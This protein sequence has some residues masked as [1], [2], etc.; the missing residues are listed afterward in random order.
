M[1]SKAM[2]PK[3]RSNGQWKDSIRGDYFPDNWKVLAEEV[4]GEANYV[5]Q[6]GGHRCTGI[7]T[8]VD[9]IDGNRENHER[10]NLQAIC[11]DC[12]KEKSSREG[13]E[14]RFYVGDKEEAE[15]PANITDKNGAEDSLAERVLN[16]KS[17]KDFRRY[18]GPMHE[19]DANGF[20]KLPQH[21]IGRIVI[22]WITR[23]LRHK[24]EP[25]K[26]T[27][28]QARFI[29]W[30]YAVNES[31]G[32]LNRKAIM[33]RSKGWG[34]DP[35][36]AALCAV[37]F[38]GPCRFDGYDSQGRIRAKEEQDAWVQLLAVTLKQN[39]N[40]MLI[41]KSMFSEELK[42][43]YGLE[44]NAWDI[45]ALGGTRFIECI[46]S[47]ANALEGNR[48]TFAICNETQ[49]WVQSN[50]GHYLWEIL[51]G[52]VSKVQNSHMLSITN[53]YNPALDSIAQQQFETCE[54]FAD[55]KTSDP[56]ILIDYRGVS[57]DIPLKTIEERLEAL[58]FAYQDSTQ[59][60][61][62][63]EIAEEL[64]DASVDVMNYGR[65]F[66][67]M[68][69]I[70][71]QTWV[72]IRE[73]DRCA[74]DAS[75][76]PYGSRIVLA[77]DGSLNDDCTVLLGIVV[78]GKYD[79]L[80]IPLGIWS[81]PPKSAGEA[82]ENYRVPRE[83]V[84]K[85]VEEIHKLYKVIAFFADPSHKKDNNGGGSYWMPYINRWNIRYSNKYQ[86]HANPGKHSV[87]WDMTSSARQKDFRE[88]LALLQQ[89]ITD[90]TV[91]HNGDK[92]LRAHVQNARVSVNINGDRSISKV[93]S[94][95]DKKIDYA[96]VWGIAFM[97]YMMVTSSKKTRKNT[98]RSAQPANLVK[99][100]D[101]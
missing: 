54:K 13:V 47:S 62:V 1:H 86:F 99:D 25:F 88:A 32:W 41:L 80:A 61:N 19:R 28:E 68:I 29:M 12:H 35:L 43:R 96:V 8:E 24:G 21:T 101:G 76:L 2:I 56:R 17:R 18:M 79:G 45:K 15:H 98:L 20:Y 5:C 16:R 91:R 48:V 23:N 78:G 84:D 71:S 40:T 33:F 100:N 65:K 34:K 70:D 77:F 42:Q 57:S 44:F 11:T 73:F 94:Q 69:G 64:D 87:N 60:V 58:N 59:F 46:P 36:A 30:F 75:G 52:N 89:E 74:F 53:T 39:K 63:R 49:H 92:D 83:D 97:M 51:T 95:S 66:L 14:A 26:L 93:S 22:A 27:G 37:E 3:I 72:D 85:R 10:E 38:I 31:G 7:A 55:G 9:H 50:R 81:K 82:Y 90:N 6:V 4:L 67:S